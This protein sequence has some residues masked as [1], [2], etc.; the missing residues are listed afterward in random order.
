MIRNIFSDGITEDIITELS[1]FHELFVIARNSSFSFRNQPITVSEIG[2]K[3]GA[4]YVLEG[5]VRKSGNRVRISAQLIDAESSNH[6]WA[7]RFD[8]N[9]EDIFAVQDEVVGIITATLVGRVEH[10]YRDRVIRLPTSNLRAYDWFV[11]GR[12]HFYNGTSDD[13]ISACELFRK[14]ISIDNDYAAAYALLAETNIRDWITFWN[15]PLEN[16]YQNAW[17]NAKKAVSLDQNDSRTQLAL[18]VVSLFSGDHNQ[19]QYHLEKALKLNPSDTRILFYMSRYDVLSGNPEKAVERISEARRHNPFGKY[20]WGLVPAYYAMHRYAEIIEVMRG[21]PN[22]AAIQLCWMAATYA[23]S[24]N[25]DQASQCAEQFVT[26]VKIK[27]DSIGEM[28]PYSW[29]TFLSERWPIKEKNDR[30]HFIEG[31]RKAGIPE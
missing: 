22:P 12:E 16:S 21:I 25:L 11:Q 31:L 4:Q 7:E 24:G 29:L 2:Q 28:L 8:R 15:E 10:A 14:A 5:S 1:R 9:L 20:D 18:G 6:V 27:L 23:Q 3:L 17:D 30:D 13:N 26:E 19:A